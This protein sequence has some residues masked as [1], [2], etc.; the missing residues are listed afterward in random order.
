LLSL[1]GA[2][3]LV[4][5]D[6]DPAKLELAL[7]RGATH[8]VEAGSATTAARVARIADGGVTH[9]FEVVGRPETMRLAWDVLRPGGTAIVV[10][11]TVYT[12]SFKTG[13]TLGIDVRT[14]RKTFSL[15]QAGYT[16]VVSD[17]RRLYAL[18][19]YTLIGLE[20]AKR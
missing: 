18:G 2:S 20:P 14:H 13:E 12:S 10:G 17:G 16:P 5:V 15:R 7:A 6:L 9:A 8:A 4:A 11:H 1:A 19:Y 3:P